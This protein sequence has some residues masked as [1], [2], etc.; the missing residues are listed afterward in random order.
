MAS[1]ASKVRRERQNTPKKQVAVDVQKIFLSPP[2]KLS[3]RAILLGMLVVTFMIF[4]GPLKFSQV[5]P[6]EA[7]FTAMLPAASLSWGW[8]VFLRYKFRKGEYLKQK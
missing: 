3:E 2:R 7:A 4:F 8:M 1:S 5:P 6:L